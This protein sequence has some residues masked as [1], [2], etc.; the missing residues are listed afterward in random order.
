MISVISGGITSFAAKKSRGFWLRR[1]MSREKMFSLSEKLYLQYCLYSIGVLIVAFV[2]VGSY[3]DFSNRLLSLG[4]PLLL[5]G[6]LV[7][8]YL[9]FLITKDLGILEII[10]A[11]GTMAVIVRTAFYIA[12]SEFNAN[13]I[14]AI[15]LLLLAAAI[16]YRF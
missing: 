12:D 11:V 3:L 2:L 14:I 9:G 1:D 5:I 8:F 4:F 13:T 10:L 15:E 6:T 7:S 16:G